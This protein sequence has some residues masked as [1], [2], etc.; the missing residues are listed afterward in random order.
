MAFSYDIFLIFILYVLLSLSLFP[1]I[2]IL[3]ANVQILCNLIGQ[4]EYKIGRNILNIGVNIVLFGEKNLATFEFRG[5][6]KKI[7]SLR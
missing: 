1:I 4:E 6:K 5:T 2:L 7:T 3:I